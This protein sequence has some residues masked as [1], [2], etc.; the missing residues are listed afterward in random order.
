MLRRSLLLIMLRQSRAIGIA[1]PRIGQKQFSLNAPAPRLKKSCRG[2]EMSYLFW[3]RSLAGIFLHP[4]DAPMLVPASRTAWRHELDRWF[5]SHRI[6]P[7]I[8]AEFDEAALMKTADADGLVLVPIATV[9][10]E[11]VVER[12]GLVRIGRPVRCGFSCCLITLE[13]AMRHPAVAVVAGEARERGIFTKAEDEKLIVLRQ[14]ALRKP[15]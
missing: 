12:Y 3:R 2:V 6:R 11:E 14:Q 1:A 5:D 10:L 8:V 4:K 7:R 13:C 15:G 9:V